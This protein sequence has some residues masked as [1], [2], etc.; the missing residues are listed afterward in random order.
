MCVPT[1][2]A[3]LSR[4]VAAG[5]R[6]LVNHQ[7][8]PKDMLTTALYCEMW[9]KWIHIMNSRCESTSLSYKNMDEFN[10]WME[11][12]KEFVYFIDSLQVHPKDKARKPF[13]KGAIL[14]TISTMDQAKELLDEGKVDF[15]LPRYNR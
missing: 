12:F 11:F 10:E 5:L 15:F 13:Q 3:V 8:Y 7:G 9:G 6:I 1:A 14:T 2:M 4:D